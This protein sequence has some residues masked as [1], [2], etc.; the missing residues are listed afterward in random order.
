MIA[1]KKPPHPFHPTSKTKSFFFPP[2]VVCLSGEGYF[3]AGRVGTGS[4]YWRLSGVLPQR[5][6]TGKWDLCDAK[7]C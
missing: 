1:G 2:T 6:W 3:L 7:R 4:A 5:P